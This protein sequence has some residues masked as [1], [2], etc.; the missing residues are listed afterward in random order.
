M[1]RV[2]SGL[3][4]FAEKLAVFLVAIP[5]CAA[6]VNREPAHCSPW[7]SLSGVFVVCHG[8]CGGC[9]GAAHGRRFASGFASVTRHPPAAV[10]EDEASSSPHGKI[11]A[12][13]RLALHGNQLHRNEPLAEELPP[14]RLPAAER[15]ET[16][17][18]WTTTS[19]YAQLSQNEPHFTCWFEFAGGCDG[20]CG[21][22]LRGNSY[23]GDEN[24][25]STGTGPSE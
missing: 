25:C 10:T 6:R 14:T 16:L 24:S 7:P 17:H 18:K 1:Q 5:F 9:L 13:L 22:L 2:Q 19:F 23:V 8:H 11:D 3:A 15:P 4:L 12:A 20:L 21:R